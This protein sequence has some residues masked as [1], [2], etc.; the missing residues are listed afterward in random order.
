MTSTERGRERE[1]PEEWL[2]EAPS[3]SQMDG[4]KQKQASSLFKV[5]SF[6]QTSPQS[7]QK[8]LLFLFLLPPLYQHPPSLP[9][10]FSSRA[11]D[12]DLSLNHYS[13]RNEQKRGTGLCLPS[14][15]SFPLPNSLLHLQHPLDSFSLVL[16]Q[17]SPSRVVSRRDQSA[18]GREK[19]YNLPLQQDR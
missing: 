3:L 16:K 2:F 5:H 17:C 1:R 9:P 8:Q 11:R 6:A 4:M 7:K 19:P 13:I 10:S 18:P 15:D 12:N 14:H